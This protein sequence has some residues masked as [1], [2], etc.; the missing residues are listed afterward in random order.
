VRT[1]V[2]RM[3]GRSS[4]IAVM[5]EEVVP[6]ALP[7]QCH[8]YVSLPVSEIHVSFHQGLCKTQNEAPLVQTIS[9]L[10]WVLFAACTVHS[11]KI[12]IHAKRREHE[13]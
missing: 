12:D 13:S 3:S 7:R 2:R 5:V 8:R 4:R 10:T 6:P 11:H 9:F 1:E